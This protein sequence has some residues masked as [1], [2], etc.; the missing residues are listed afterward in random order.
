MDSGVSPAALA[1]CGPRSLP[2]APPV[3]GC[4]PEQERPRSHSE[5]ARPPEASTRRFHGNLSSSWLRRGAGQGKSDAL[6][7]FSSTW[8][9]IYGHTKKTDYDGL[10]LEASLR[11]TLEG[12][13]WRVQVTGRRSYF[14]KIW[15]SG[16]TKE[17]SMHRPARDRKLLRL[18]LK[19]REFYQHGLKKEAP[20]RPRYTPSSWTKGCSWSHGHRKN[21]LEERFMVRFFSR[22]SNTL[23]YTDVR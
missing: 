20:P 19:S 12:F 14:A 22:T 17:P 2:S 9:S 18:C 1:S 13:V 16:T 3:P 21:L 10:Q 15:W 8:S 7:C 6:R 5:T 4:I 23:I 11:A